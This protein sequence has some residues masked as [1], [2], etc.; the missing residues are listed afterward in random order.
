M[1]GSR[2][3]GGADL[4]DVGLD[5]ARDFHKGR[6]KLLLAM[7]SF[8]VA[9]LAAF[10][11]YL[12]Q[13]QPNPY[14]ELGK[15]VNGLRGKYFD[16]FLVCA[17]PGADLSTIKSD[18]DL[19]NE[20]DA[21]AASGAR[22]G[23]HLRGCAAP[24]SELNTSLRTLIPPTDAAQLVVAMADGVAKLS[25]GSQAFATHLEGL[26]GPYKPD[27]GAVEAEALIRGWYEFRKAHA[28]LNSL[29]KSKLGR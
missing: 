21:R 26:E 9:G 11:W 4:P 12:L 16:A 23:A 10:A 24:L 20:F 8:V 15:Q 2:N 7:I 18:A 5:D 17:L 13:D 28:E 29:I 25:V 1:Q 19:R 27:E 6:G 22:Y 14:G 3:M